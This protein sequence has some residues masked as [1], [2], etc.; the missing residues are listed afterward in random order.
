M[1]QPRYVMLDCV[2]QSASCSCSG[3]LFRGHPPLL[4]APSIRFPQQPA[5]LYNWCGCREE[6][7][8]GEGDSVTKMHEDL[9]GGWRV[10]QCL[11]GCSMC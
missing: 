4:W 10:V 8:Q 6:E 9:S 2:M 1:Q 3:W 7:H 5:C 11:A